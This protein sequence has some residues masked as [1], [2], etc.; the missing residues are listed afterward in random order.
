MTLETPFR[1]LFPQNIFTKHLLTAKYC[2]SL[3]DAMRNQN[4]KTLLSF[5]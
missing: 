5:L 1:H 4:D 2:F 3:G